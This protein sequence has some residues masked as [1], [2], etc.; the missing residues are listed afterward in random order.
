MSS[1]I[2]AYIDNFYSRLYSDDPT[3]IMIAKHDGKLMLFQT[4][5]CILVNSFRLRY[6]KGK[7]ATYLQYCTVDGLEPMDDFDNIAVLIDQNN[8]KVRVTVL[9]IKY[10]DIIYS[11]K[12][13]NSLGCD[14]D[15]LTCLAVSRNCFYYIIAFF[16]YHTNGFLLSDS[17][18]SYED[19][20]SI[21]EKE[22]FNRKE[23]R[24]RQ[25]EQ[26]HPLEVSA[27]YPEKRAQR[28]FLMAGDPHEQE[29]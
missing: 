24:P 12:D 22:I 25:P 16:G 23:L 28:P 27:S 15:V 9:D 8:Q 10:G 11:S 20:L 13:D 14:T 26:H 29:F 6:Q 18:K 19:L 5:N 21:I 7:D 4:Q 17:D 2:E 1:N 3:A